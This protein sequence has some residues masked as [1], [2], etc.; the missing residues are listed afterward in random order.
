MFRLFYEHTGTALT[1]RMC[2]PFEQLLLPREDRR[3]TSS[4]R[5]KRSIDWE[6][7][8][9]MPYSTNNMG[10]VCEGIRYCLECGR[11]LCRRLPSYNTGGIHAIEYLVR[12]TLNALKRIGLQSKA[13]HSIAQHCIAQHCIALHC[14]ALHCI[15]LHCIAL[16]C[17]ALHC[18]CSGGDR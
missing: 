5:G 8:T 16:H 13:Q 7:H 4:I 6:E 15:A 10:H 1:A 3:H 11:V 9:V 17:I 12:R 14:I 18:N 2:K